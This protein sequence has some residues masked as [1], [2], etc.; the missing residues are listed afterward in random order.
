MVSGVSRAE[1]NTCQ[2]LETATCQ[3]KQPVHETLGVCFRPEMSRSMPAKHRLPHWPD[4]YFD[5]PFVRGSTIDKNYNPVTN[6]FV[7]ANDG[8]LASGVRRRHRWVGGA[9]T[10]TEAQAPVVVRAPATLVLT[11]LCRIPGRL[12]DRRQLGR[13]R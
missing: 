13:Q 2:P 9:V 8:G 12:W 11:P 7:G 6:E 1:G 10:G 5:N 3:Y 4:V